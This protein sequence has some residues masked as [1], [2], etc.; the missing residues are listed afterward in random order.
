MDGAIRL[1]MDNDWETQ[2]SCL[3]RFVCGFLTGWLARLYGYK[4]ML[5]LS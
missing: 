3:D 2:L 4:N 5:S 1:R